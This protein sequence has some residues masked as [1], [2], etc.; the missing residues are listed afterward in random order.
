MKCIF[1]L[2]LL[3]NFIFNQKCVANTPQNEVNN[4]KVYENIRVEGESF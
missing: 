4:Y 2:F 1:K 3:V